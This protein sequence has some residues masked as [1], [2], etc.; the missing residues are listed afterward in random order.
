MFPDVSL[1]GP[2][3]LP[4]RHP[5]KDAEKESC[6]RQKILGSLGSHNPGSLEAFKNL[7]LRCLSDRRM[8]AA[9]A[10]VS[11]SVMNEYR[12]A[13]WERERSRMVRRLWK[14]VDLKE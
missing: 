10:P 5:L 13:E 9:P 7:S 8:L 4:C 11:A 12:V 14:E 6:L 1:D 3:S 2:S